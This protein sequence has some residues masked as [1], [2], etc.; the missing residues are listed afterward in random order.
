MYLK[1]HLKVKYEI[2]LIFSQQI[3]ATCLPFVSV[4]LNASQATTDIQVYNS[5]KVS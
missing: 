3:F 4:Y 2:F 5:V 1:R